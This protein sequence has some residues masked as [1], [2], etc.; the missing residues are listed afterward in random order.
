MATKQVATVFS[1]PNETRFRSTSHHQRKYVE[2][3][4]AEGRDKFFF[5]LKIKT[6][7]FS[8]IY[9]CSIQGILREVYKPN[10]TREEI[11]SMEDIQLSNL[12]KNKR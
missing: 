4:L 8:N 5:F 6:I 12:N 2:S 3:S 7:S 11:S 9:F 10:N 1:F